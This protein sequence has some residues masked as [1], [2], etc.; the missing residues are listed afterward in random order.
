MPCSGLKLAAAGRPVPLLLAIDADVSGRP[1]WRPSLCRCSRLTLHASTSRRSCSRSSVDYMRS[2]AT[3]TTSSPLPSPSLHGE[4]GPADHVRG[5]NDARRGPGSGT[6]WQTPWRLSSFSRRAT[7]PA[8]CCW[9]FCTSDFF[10]FGTGGT[11]PNRGGRCHYTETQ[12]EIVLVAT[13]LIVRL[14]TIL[15][16]LVPATASS[17]QC[18]SSLSSSNMH[19]C[20]ASSN[21][22]LDGCSLS[23]SRRSPRERLV[24]LQQSLALLAIEVMVWVPSCLDHGG[25]ASSM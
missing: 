12:P 5:A 19:G 21:R 20:M 17:P 7:R 22:D 25:M 18:P 16:K 13:V 14:H 24:R 23:S 11:Y 15:R 6:D 8:G 10:A 9:S 3:T 1:S 2:T 4:A